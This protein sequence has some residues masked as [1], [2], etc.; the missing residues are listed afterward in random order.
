MLASSPYVSERCVMG[1][2][3]TKSAVDLGG[4]D[5]AITRF[6][7]AIVGPATIEETRGPLELGRTI[8]ALFTDATFLACALHARDEQAI[9]AGVARY[10][11][12]HLNLHEARGQF[13]PV[14]RLFCIHSRPFPPSQMGRYHRPPPTRS[15]HHHH[16]QP[17]ASG[18]PRCRIVFAVHL[19]R[20][21]R[22]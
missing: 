12:F 22:Q 14:W 20:Y 2:G 17:P 16:H 7:I 15:H 8:S 5:R 6:V 18:L 1:V 10:I 4:I 3:R 9:R 11:D 19:C 13:E 21:G